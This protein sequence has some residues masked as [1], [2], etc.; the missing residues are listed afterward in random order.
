MSYLVLARKWRPKTFAD[1]VG[2]EHV[3]RALANALESDRVHHAYLFAGTRGVGKTTIARILAKALN[4]EAGVSAEPCGRCDSCTAIDEGR[5]VDL[6]EVDAASRTKVDDTRELLEN[7]QYTPAAGRYK[8]Y[9]IDEVHMLSRS[10]F[11]AFLKTLEEPPAHVKFLLATTDPQKLPVTVLSR[12][13]Q[14]NLKR[15]P[16]ALIEQRMQQIC[17]AEG[18]DAEPGALAR[19]ARAADGSVRDALSLLDQALAFGGGGLRDADV[20]SLL[21]T[22]DRGQVLGLLDAVA[23]GDANV[24]LERIAALDEDVPD[25]ERVLDDLATLLQRVA[26]AQLAGA[27]AVAGEDGG[28]ILQSLAGRLQPA[29]VQLYY[30]VAITSRRDLSLA[31]E[32]R[33]GFEMALLRMLAFRPAPDDAMPKA[34]APRRLSQAAARRQQSPPATTASPAAPGGSAAGVADWPALVTDLGLSG[35]LRT[36]ADNCELVEATDEQLHLRL[37]RRNAHL[38]TRRLKERLTERLRERFGAGVKVR[39]ELVEEAGETVADRAARAERERERQMRE[40]L[41]NDPEVREL[42]DS[43]DAELAQESIRPI[44][45]GRGPASD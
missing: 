4:C 14:F 27:E 25:Y 45:A 9:L 7:V 36:L 38:A 10:S 20:A 3:L 44:D 30:Q 6:I 41:G 40:Q 12:C 13:L 15:L 28:E 2:Q 23:A 43:F 34:G 32:P 39:L 18:I 1:V 19:L 37:A 16:V 24:L 17:A 5:F 42:V 11:N 29:Q 22:L 31:P 21:G 33:L 26:V 35:A 8:V